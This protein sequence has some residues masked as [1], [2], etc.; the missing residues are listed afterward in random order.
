[1]S[2]CVGGW[3]PLSQALES[4]T[5][6]PHPQ[7]PIHPSSLPHPHCVQALGKRLPF[8]FL[9]DAQQQFQQRYGG[10]AAGAVAYE[11]NTEYAPV[12]RDRMRFFNTD[13]RWVPM[14]LVGGWVGW[15]EEWY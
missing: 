14:A 11:M 6:H 12:L 8:A 9:A 1:M 5:P 13:P 3:A 10:V 15:C 7:H 2:E 4:D